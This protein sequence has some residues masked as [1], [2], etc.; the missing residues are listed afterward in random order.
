MARQQG[1]APPVALTGAPDSNPLV[2]E[3]SE[4]ENSP[5]PPPP[6]PPLPQQ[7]PPGGP[8]GVGAAL[9]V[10]VLGAPDVP[11]APIRMSWDTLV[12]HLEF[13]NRSLAVQKWGV[14]ACCK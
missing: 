8:A 5:V 3:E 12:E 7:P 1:Q 11:A 6:P 9:V 2:E 14:A 4:D 13:M 10:E